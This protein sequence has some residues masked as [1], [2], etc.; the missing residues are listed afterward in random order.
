MPTVLKSLSRAL[1]F[2]YRSIKKNIPVINCIESQL[3]NNS[4]SEWLFARRV[5][6]ITFI[7]LF[8]RHRANNVEKSI[9][10]T[11]SRATSAGLWRY[12]SVKILDS[13]NFLLEGSTFLLEG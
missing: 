11:R 4:C 7:S 3:Y 6:R 5:G 9:C 10:T 8:A 13:I 12:N 2:N 1:N